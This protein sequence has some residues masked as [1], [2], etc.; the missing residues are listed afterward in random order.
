MEPVWLARIKIRSCEFAVPQIVVEAS[1]EN[2][3]GNPILQTL[4]IKIDEGNEE[5]T[6]DPRMCPRG[7]TGELMGEIIENGKDKNH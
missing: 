6:F 1:G 3:L 2:L 5:F 4:G 7:R